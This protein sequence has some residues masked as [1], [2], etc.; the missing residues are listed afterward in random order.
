MVQPGPLSWDALPSRPKR[1]WLW[2][3]V[4]FALVALLVAAAATVTLPYYAIAPGSAREVN[5]LIQPPPDHRYPPRGAVFLTTVSLR[6]VTP[7]EA[8]YGWLNTNIDVVPQD[9]ILP[10]ATKPSELQ[11]ANF[12]AMDESKQVAAVVAMRRL[13]YSVP[14]HGEGAG[15]VEIVKDSP[16]DAH[17]KAG[18][19]V[20]AV[21]GKPVQLSDD[22]VSAI[23]HHKP[24]DHLVLEIDHGGGSPKRTEDITLGAAPADRSVCQSVAQAG[25]PASEGNIPCLGVRLQTK[26]LRFDF[27][28]TV[29]VDS[30]GIGG[31]S[32]GLAF[33][34]GILDALRPGELTGGHRV[35]VT[36]TISLDGSVGPVGGVVQKT[37][38]VR[39][40]GIGLFLVPPEEY[41]MARARAGSKLK[42]VKVAT[43][44]EA[45]AALAAQG[46]DLSA[47]GPSPAGAPG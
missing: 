3:A 16:A 7:I 11:R 37:A 22:V 1:R 26:Q 9:Q 13:G 30:A 12:Q 24:G 46:G 6:R 29:N 10:P 44:D 21:D 33:T 5:D 40:A 15:I 8:A 18:E 34:L 42:V 27:P 47:L 19:V 38:A 45:L 35:A 43:L 25:R 36:G 20:T 39:A 17:L 23:G 2:W 4:P 32:A 31:P 14:E 41:A 28:F